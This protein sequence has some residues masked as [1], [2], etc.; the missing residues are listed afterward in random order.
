MGY[1]K[2]NLFVCVGNVDRSKSGEEVYRQMLQERGFIVEPFASI[3]DV[4]FYVGSAG[5]EVSAPNAF[6]GSVQLTSGLVALA[7]RIFS[8]GELVT[9]RLVVD[10]GAHPRE[11]IQLDI[12]DGR[13][14]LVPDQAR[15]LYGE[16]FLK[17]MP[18]VPQRR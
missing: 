14:L 15:S 11:I 12:E 5:I 17:L 16:F 2:R 6:N 4:D 7:N 13:S 10:F 18:Y 3:A 9:Q 8:V 1:P